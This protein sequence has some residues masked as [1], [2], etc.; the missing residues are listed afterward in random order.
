MDVLEKLENIGMNNI[1][2]SV[3]SFG[4]AVYVST[5]IGENEGES[6]HDWS[7]RVLNILNAKFP[8]IN[9]EGS[10]ANPMTI[11]ARREWIVTAFMVIYRIAAK[12][13]SP[14]QNYFYEMHS[15]IRDIASKTRLG[16]FSMFQ[17][18][19]TGFAAQK[20]LFYMYRE[21]IRVL[22]LFRDT[23]KLEKFRDITNLIK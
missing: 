1:F 15:H 16:A 7:V 17:W 20:E 3:T 10:V 2:E 14:D 23:G 11:R 6:V 5:Q 13:D 18:E 9:Y 8:E 22:T 21:S 19:R 4:K 12:I